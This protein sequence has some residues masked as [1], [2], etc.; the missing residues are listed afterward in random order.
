[1]HP[2]SRL[3]LSVSEA[4]RTAH[5]QLNICNWRILVMS[6]AMGYQVCSDPILEFSEHI[7]GLS[8]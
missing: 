1:M 4:L 8:P 3:I 2:I 6:A 5:V 7:D